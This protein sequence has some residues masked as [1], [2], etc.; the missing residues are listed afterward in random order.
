M[1]QTDKQ[2]KNMM[3]LFRLLSMAWKISMGEGLQVREDEVEW[4]MEI[5]RGEIEYDDL[6]ENSEMMF[7][8]I[9]SNFESLD[10]QEKPDIEVQKE[11]LLK[12]RKNEQY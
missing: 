2:L 4:L 5:R 8:L 12:F 10:L 6:M 11:L 3:H 9:K 1:Q 7:D